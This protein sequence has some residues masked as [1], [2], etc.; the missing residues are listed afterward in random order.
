MSKPVALPPLGAQKHAIHWV[1]PFETEVVI[2]FDCPCLDGVPCKEQAQEY[3]QC[4]QQQRQNR[5][6]KITCDPAETRWMACIMEKQ[7]GGAEE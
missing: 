5:R 4:V 7:K 2:D 6:V 1:D 3:L